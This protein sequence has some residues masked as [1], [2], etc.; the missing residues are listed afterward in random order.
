MKVDK[1]K[2]EA[3]TKTRAFHGVI[4]KSLLFFFLIIIFYSCKQ[5]FFFFFNCRAVVWDWE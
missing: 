5:T 3:I 2:S 4:R 1:E